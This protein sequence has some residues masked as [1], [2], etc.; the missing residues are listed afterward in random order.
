MLSSDLVPEEG[1]GH[2]RLDEPLQQLLED[3]REIALIVK[4]V[5]GVGVPDCSEIVRHAHHVHVV[6]RAGSLLRTGVEG[7]EFPEAFGV[8]L[9]AA[10]RLL[11]EVIAE[12]LRA[13]LPLDHVAVLPTCHP[14]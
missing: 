7:A 5:P 13:S 6:V 4:E 9:A 2:T 3:R 11:F 10:A 14:G 1:V 8:A 12:L